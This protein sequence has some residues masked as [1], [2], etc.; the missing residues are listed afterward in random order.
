M[1]PADSDV[2]AGRFVVVSGGWCVDEDAGTI[3]TSTGGCVSLTM[4][5]DAPQPIENFLMRGNKE[6]EE[7]IVVENCI[8]H[9]EI[10]FDSFSD[11]DDCR[12]FTLLLFFNVFTIHGEKSREPGGEIFLFFFIVTRRGAQ[13]VCY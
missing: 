2:I 11:V 9:I 12:H 1:L 3:A 5:F 6:Q 8:K 4:L 10:S 7:K 13:N